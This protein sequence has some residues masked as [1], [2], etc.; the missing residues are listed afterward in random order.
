MCPSRT[1]ESAPSTCHEERIR[2]SAERLC[3][4]R[5]AARSRSIHR[6]FAGLMLAQWAVAVV[7]A[8]LLSPYTW[9]GTTR[10]IHPHVYM[11]I[12]L[13]GGLTLVTATFVRCWPDRAVTRHA[14][15]TTQMLASGMLI[16]LMGGR[17]EAHFHI[18]GSL[19][20]L[21][22]YRDPWPLL[23][24]TMVVALDHLLRQVLWPRSVYGTL[25]PEWWRFLEHAGWVLFEDVFLMV[26]CA[27]GAREMR[28]DAEQQTRIEVTERARQEMADAARIQTAILPRSTAACGLEISAKMVPASDVGGDYYDVLPADAGC[29]LAIGDVAGHGLSAG[30][31][32][33]QVQSAVQAL[34]STRP[35]LS[36]RALLSSLNRVMFENIRERMSSDDH[37]TLNLIRY[38]D[39]GRLVI[40]GAHEEIIHFEATTGRCRLLPALGTWIGVLRCIDA[41]TVE[42]TVRLAPGDLVVLYTDG[43]T[44]AQ[45]P[46]GEQLGL[47]RII[48]LV[49]RHAAEP[50]ERLRDRLFDLAE[51]WTAGP[52]DD[53]VT[54]MLLRQQGTSAPAPGAAAGAPRGPET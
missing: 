10:S 20:F 9:A 23:T 46:D 22:F 19:A 14:V 15:A 29:W 44:E 43:L 45:G 1:T 6:M 31:V 3:R 17:I 7:L 40:A 47:D 4:Q 49:E 41:V 24:A 25:D 50:L 33:L 30:M 54:I 26:A 27:R 34:A 8:L 48:E 53:D 2:A 18:F 35:G 12:L 37:M 52:A 5:H 39:D 13:G 21:A 38:H 32:M 16:D 11:A 51:R 42:T 28:R 36:P